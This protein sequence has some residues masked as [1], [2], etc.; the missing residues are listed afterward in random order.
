MTEKSFLF[1]GTPADT[2][3]L[4]HLKPMMKG[5]K[6]FVDLKPISTL[7]EVEIYC[8]NK[9][10]NIS[11]ILSTSTDLLSR[12]I[13][14]KVS[15]ISDYAGSYFKHKG[16]EIVFCD[17]L[18]QLFTVPYGKFLLER[19]SSKLSDAGSWYKSPTFSWSILDARNIQDAYDWLET[20]YAIAVDIETFS[21]PLSIRCI[22][23]T[24]IY[25]SGNEFT[26]RSF[27]LPIGDMW[28][29]QWMRK[30]VSTRP[31]KIFQNGKY[32]I[33]YLT[34][35]GAP[36]Q[37][38]L[39]DT[40]NLFHCWYSELPKDLAFLQAFFVRDAAYWKD[41]AE[42][43]DLETYYLYNAK[44]TWATAI[45]FLVWMKQAP[46]W[47]RQNYLKEFPLVFPCH[48]CEMTGIARDI[49]RLNDAREKVNTRIITESSRLD[50]MLGKKNFNVNSPIQMKQLL[51]I[52][53]CGD[54]PN[55]DAK[56]LAKAAF[57]HPLNGKILR[58]ITGITGSK[59][60]DE[61]GIRGLR[62]LKSTYV[63]TDADITAKSPG[64]SKE[65]HGR[66]LYS[67]NPH[68]TDTAR[69]ASKEH[70]FWCG[71][72]IHNIPTGD[73]VKSTIVSDPDFLFGEVDSE[74][75]ETRDTA[76]ITGDAALIAAVE[77]VKDF[78]SI[79]ASAFFGVPYE[80]IYDQKTGKKL[81]KK[82]RDL[83]KRVNHGANYNMGAKVLVDTMGEEKIY[84]AARLLGLR[85]GMT[86]IEIAEYLLDKFDRT[87]PTIR[88]A[89][90]AWIKK[91]IATTKML[92]GATGWTR[93]CFG[94]PRE[95]KQ[96]LNAYV[97]HC[98][99]SLNGMRLNIAFMKIFYE[100]AMNPEYQDSFKLLAQ[101]HDSV[102]FMYRIGFEH[103]AYKIKEIMETPMEVKGI[104]GIVRRYTVPAAVKIG[105]KFWSELE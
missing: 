12:I 18:E 100:I 92:V 10:R 35:Y 59:D 83:A 45:A 69:L 8:A 19:Y 77:S 30:L 82:L 76:Y 9:T 70:H 57:R 52:L 94:N 23:F 40:A 65:F 21:S 11:G 56:A 34:R 5:H 93:Y 48:L 97:A 64:G 95:N 63:R 74:Q 22:G 38:Y 55:A 62:K 102:L 27:V 87:Y 28:S 43:N 17:P 60:P 24:G 101:I 88:G 3:Y 58:V 91:E 15:K 6:T 104:D 96:A 4:S 14:K 25:D 86:A 42:S 99:Q 36:V 39:W 105:G 49:P 29:V 33:S 79:N 72:Q 31:A 103:L 1:L 2:P 26:T 81:D 71:L 20:C 78:H 89:Y 84:E 37:N 66:I 47:A 32:D 53:G 85:R 75:A 61:M 80:K 73:L 51:K 90:Q 41:L 54:L 44:D 7:A 50:R 67:I 13:G 46:A 68:G 16:L 98:P